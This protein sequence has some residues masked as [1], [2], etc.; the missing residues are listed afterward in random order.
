MCA[1]DCFLRGVGKDEPALVDLH[2]M[3]LELGQRVGFLHLK[4]NRDQFPP[5]LVRCKRD[6]SKLLV[7]YHS[8]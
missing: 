7:V 3:I 6:S 4:I 2:V 5:E 8:N 1:I